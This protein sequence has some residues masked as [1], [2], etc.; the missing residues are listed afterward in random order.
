MSPTARAIDANRR[1]TDV[2]MVPATGVLDDELREEADPDHANGEVHERALDADVL[3]VFSGNV[4]PQD[5][6]AEEPAEVRQ[7]AHEPDDRLEPGDFPVEDT[8]PHDDDDDSVDAGVPEDDGGSMS[9]WPVQ[10]AAARITVTL[11]TADPTIVPTPMTGCSRRTEDSDV[12]NSGSEEPMAATE[13][14]R[15]ASGTSKMRDAAHA[16]DEVVGHVL[17][18]DERTDECNGGDDHPRDHIGPI[19]CRLIDLLLPRS[20]GVQ[21]R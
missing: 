9:Q 17:E 6:I 5:C 4:F 12:N 2:E 3:D 21:I 19:Q 20:A 14:P 8:R 18:E 10:P 15:T 13:A 11:N 1:T 7:V 16:V